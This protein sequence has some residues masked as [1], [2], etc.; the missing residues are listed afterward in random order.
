MDGVGYTSVRSYRMK[1]LGGLVGLVLMGAVGWCVSTASAQDVRSPDA[2]APDI[3]LTLNEALKLKSSPASNRDDYREIPPKTDRVAES[4]RVTVTV[5]DQRCYP[6]EEGV[7]PMP[8]RS[9]T[10]NSPPVRLR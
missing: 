9:V 10:G 5:G 6:G 2:R 3:G 1:T 4:T 7:V 8:A